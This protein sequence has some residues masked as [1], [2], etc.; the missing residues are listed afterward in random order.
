MYLHKQAE[1]KYRNEVELPQIEQTREKLNALKD[2]HWPIKWEELDE[3]EKDYQEKKRLKIDQKRIEREKYY[4]DIGQGVYDSKQYSTKVHEIYLE[5]EKIKKIE[6]EKAWEDLI[7]K[8]EKMN[9]YA[10]LVKEMHFPKAS[11][12]KK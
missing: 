5:S 11:N 8:S 1:E 4:T 7:K 9:S 12:R 3:F 6:E 2:F 10:K